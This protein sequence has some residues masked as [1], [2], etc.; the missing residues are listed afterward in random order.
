M[1]HRASLCVHNL[2]FLILNMLICNESLS[3]KDFILQFQLRLV[4]ERGLFPDD[5]TQ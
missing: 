3:F 1:K 4:F 2:G 5:F